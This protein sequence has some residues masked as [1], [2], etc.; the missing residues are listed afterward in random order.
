M[1]P[2]Q[3][4][5]SVLMMAV[6]VALLSVAVIATHAALRP[7]V[8]LNASQLAENPLFWWSLAASTTLIGGL[9]L[10]ALWRVNRGHFFRVGNALIHPQILTQELARIWATRF[11][12]LPPPSDVWLS[13]GRNWQI[14]LTLPVDSEGLLKEIDHEVGQLMRTRFGYSGP[15]S[16]L[17]RTR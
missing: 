7:E 9:L 17:V 6:S 16:L 3:V 14:Q 2:S 11:P 12:G 1:R 8:R 10:L 4:T 15:Y 5:S 13:L